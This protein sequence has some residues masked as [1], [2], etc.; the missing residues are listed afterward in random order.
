[1]ANENLGSTVLHEHRRVVTLRHLLALVNFIAIFASTLITRYFVMIRG[2][3]DGILLIINLLC[4]VNVLQ[5]ML[6]IIDY[7]TKVMMGK[8]SSKIVKASYIV[9]AI[10]VAMVV[11]EF[12]SGTITLGDIRIDLAVIAVFQFISAIVAY[13]VWPHIDYST[14][15]KMTHKNVRDDAGK[16]SKKATGGALQYILICLLRCCHREHTA[17]GGVGRCTQGYRHVYQ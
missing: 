13:L 17:A 9:G 5:I 12:V 1:M 7:I 11:A 4:G 3:S 16:R 6:C 2:T 8:Y 15:R 10:W 14:I